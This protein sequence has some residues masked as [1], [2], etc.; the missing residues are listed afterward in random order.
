MGAAGGLTRNLIDSISDRSGADLLQIWRNAVA[1]LSDRKRSAQHAAARDAIRIIGEEWLRRTSQPHWKEDYFPW[2]STDAPRG[3]G[4]LD[5]RGWPEE[6]LLV[7]VGYRVGQ[8]QGVATPMR[9][10]ILREVFEGELPP[11]ESPDY[12]REWG[13]PA[14]PARLRKL[15]ETLASLTRNEKRRREASLRRA[16]E[17]REDDLRFLHDEYYVGRFHFVWPDASI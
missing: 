5:A 3:G 14:T 9:R 2:P 11:V 1:I 4:G 13:P 16:I 10:A 12:I 8:T 6:G 15:A 7:A 17:Q